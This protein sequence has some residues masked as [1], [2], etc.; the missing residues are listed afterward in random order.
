[1]NSLRLAQRKSKGILLPGSGA[2]SGR[3]CT[4]QELNL[5]FRKPSVNWKVVS[6][7]TLLWLPVPASLS[8]LGSSFLNIFFF[9]I[10]LSK[11]ASAAESWLMGHL[12]PLAAIPVPSPALCYKCSPKFSH[13][14]SWCFWLADFESGVQNLLGSP[15]P[16]KNVFSPI[17]HV[18]SHPSPASEVVKLELL[19]SLHSVFHKLPSTG[20]RSPLSHSFFS[21]SISVDVSDD[22]AL[23][24]S[25]NLL[26]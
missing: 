1:M 19:P 18:V 20:L 7:L 11:V 9:F 15:P 2:P 5:E 4:C 6:V 23:P 22:F 17:C 12:T 16:P 13:C 3:K 8:L 25:A 10:T 24:T 21:Q 14:A 26:L